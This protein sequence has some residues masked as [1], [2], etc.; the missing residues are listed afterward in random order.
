MLEFIFILQKKILIKSSKKIQFNDKIELHNFEFKKI[1][2]QKKEKY[3]PSN[4]I[5]KETNF[6]EIKCEIVK[7]GDKEYYYYQ[8]ERL[9]I[10]KETNEKFILKRG[11][12][13]REHN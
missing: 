9:M 13:V 11:K 7:Y 2:K 8:P 3:N 12:L 5:I 10:C 1:I 6:T 4:E